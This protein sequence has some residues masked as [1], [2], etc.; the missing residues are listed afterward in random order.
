MSIATRTPTVST[1][2]REPL[3]LALVALLVTDLVGGVLAVA[4]DVNTWGEAW[5]SQALLA[6][7]LPMIAVQVVL[8]VLAVRLHGRKAA[9]PA[10]LLAVAC[11]ASVVSGFFDGGLGNDELTT[12]LAAYQT[13][14]LAVT[15][16]VGVLAA[17]LAWRRSRDQRG[18]Q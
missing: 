3:V 11:L 16:V 17:R 15:G 7:P 8:T 9:V 4:S 14:L 10:G 5:G 6:A 2:R 18:G 12:A 1:A 13:F